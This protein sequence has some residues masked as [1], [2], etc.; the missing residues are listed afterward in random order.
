MGE[1][2]A[3]NLVSEGYQVTVYNRSQARMTRLAGPKP[4]GA[5]R[6]AL[7]GSAHCE[8][9]GTRA[10]IRRVAPKSVLLVQ[11]PSDKHEPCS[12][13]EFRTQ[14]VLH[15]MRDLR[16]RSHMPRL[17]GQKEC[18][19]CAVSNANTQVSLRCRRS[20]SDMPL[21]NLLLILPKARVRRKLDA[22]AADG[23]PPAPWVHKPAGEHGATS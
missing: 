3:G 11:L 12:P 5:E 4:F 13:E 14:I 20:F 19:V 8:S 1:G 18:D 9:S 10:R 15:A 7:R 23:S 2:F 21:M 6:L 22:A 16:D 17:G